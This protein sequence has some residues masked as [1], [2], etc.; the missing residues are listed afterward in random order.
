MPTEEEMKALQEKMKN[1]S[2]E[3]LKEFQKQQCIFCQIIAGKVASKKVY[4]DDKVFAILDINPANPGHILLMPKEHYP[5]MPL[6][7]PEVL[8]HM[9]MVAKALSGKMLTA[10]SAEGSDIFVANGTAAGQRAQHF[11]LH[12]IPRKPGDKIKL[13]ITYNELKKKDVDDAKAKIQEKVDAIFKQQPVKTEVVPAPAEPSK[14]TSKKPAK[15][16]VKKKPEPSKKSSNVSLDDIAE[17][18]KNG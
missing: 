11:M 7:P 3:E 12:I 6:M 5:L 16:T 2:P 10:I 9:F 18:L 8:G 15:K 13:N 17:V 14:K 4:E 1:M